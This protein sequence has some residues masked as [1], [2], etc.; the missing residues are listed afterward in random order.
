VG[1]EVVIEPSRCSLILVGKIFH[2]F[3]HQLNNGNLMSHSTFRNATHQLAADQE[4]SY[5]ALH[6]ISYFFVGFLW[7]DLR[8]LK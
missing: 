4:R 5:T 1:N 8:Q 7:T 3:T 2:G 6:L